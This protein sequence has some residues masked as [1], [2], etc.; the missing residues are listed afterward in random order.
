MGKEDLSTNLLIL[1]I[2]TIIL[3]F[4]GK[5]LRVILL[6]FGSR[7][8]NNLQRLNKLEEM[9]SLKLAANSSRDKLVDAFTAPIA[10]DVRMNREAIRMQ[11]LEQLEKYVALASANPAM[12]INGVTAE[13]QVLQDE[14][15]AASCRISTS[16]SYSSSCHSSP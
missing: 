8:G 6:V 3:C 4:K 16:S 14:E 7:T 1:S 11:K 5:K 10:M 13:L 9:I 15:A 2:R 12:S